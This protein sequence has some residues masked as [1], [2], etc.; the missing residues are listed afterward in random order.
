[1]PCVIDWTITHV[2]EI[3]ANSA[4]IAAGV[5]QQQE[6]TQ[7]IAEST[8]AVLNKVTETDDR[9][10]TLAEIATAHQDM[11]DAAKEL[12]AQLGDHA[13]ALNQ[14]MDTLIGALRAA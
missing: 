3:A 5:G 2:G 12:A 6:A 13:S 10:R 4:A 7:A 14:R 8:E 9:S 11:A 1:M